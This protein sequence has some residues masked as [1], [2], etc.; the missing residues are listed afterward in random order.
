MELD[1]VEGE[2]GLRSAWPLPQSSPGVSALVR[3]SCLQEDKTNP[4]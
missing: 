2:L 3:D 4:L 1:R